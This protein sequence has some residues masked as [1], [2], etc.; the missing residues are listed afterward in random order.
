MQSSELYET[1]QHHSAEQSCVD[2]LEL[3]VNVRIF[4]FERLAICT[5][6]AS[7]QHLKAFT[8]DVQKIRIRSEKT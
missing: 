6:F 7:K 8:N 4:A 2:S 1:D 5:V 3:L